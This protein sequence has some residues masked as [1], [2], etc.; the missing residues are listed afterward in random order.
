[1][2]QV[3]RQL[4]RFGSRYRVIQARHTILLPTFTC[5][6]NRPHRP[7]LPC[8]IIFAQDVIQFHVLNV[9]NHRSIR[10]RLA[11]TMLLCHESEDAM[12]DVIRRP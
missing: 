2:A 8:G 6:D 3:E 10:R 9:A 7:F 11:V 12:L 4:R 5:G 1:M